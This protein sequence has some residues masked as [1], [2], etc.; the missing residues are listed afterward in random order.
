M[1]IG[2]V[3]H[4]YKSN[5][6]GGNLQAYALCKIISSLGYDVEQIS[7]KRIPRKKIK[8]KLY[9][10]YTCVRNYRGKRFSKLLNSRQTAI[11]IFNT[12]SIPHSKVYS[13]KDI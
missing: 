8:H 12:E 9:Q 13:D 5:N 1:R 10:V 4:Y 2:I 7:L 3:T 6:Y 11:R